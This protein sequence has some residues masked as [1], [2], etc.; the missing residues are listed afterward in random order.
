M[1]HEEFKKAWLPLS[2]VFY[3]TAWS[4]LGNEADAKDAVQELY[5]RLWNSKDKLDNV[6]SP[7]SYG[8]TIVRNIS[9]DLVR[10]KNVRRAQDIDSAAGCPS[11]EETDRGTISRETVSSLYAAMEKLPEDDRLLVRL[12][13]F[14]ELEYDEICRRTGLNPVNVR[15]RI[16]R[17]RQK[18]KTLMQI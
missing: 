17:A 18:I 10:K 4:V 15:V 1:T 14:E 13:F 5:V 11:L 16:S 7:A 6:L 8:N 2:A 9:L 12:R 3:R